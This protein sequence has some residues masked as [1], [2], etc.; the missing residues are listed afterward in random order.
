[1]HPLQLGMSCRQTSC[2][3]WKD[4]SFS[5]DYPTCL[6]SISASIILEFF[7]LF[8]NRCVNCTPKKY[9]QKNLWIENTTKLSRGQVSICF[10]YYPTPKARQIEKI[11][12]C[13]VLLEM[14]LLLQDQIESQ[15]VYP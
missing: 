12:N 14:L 15:K 7:L 4:E 2:G 6:F 8:V 11:L 10:G 9:C 13:H 3:N 1:M 5:I